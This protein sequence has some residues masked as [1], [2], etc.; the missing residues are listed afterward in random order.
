M[1]Y[2]KDFDE[3][4]YL[5]GKMTKFNALNDPNVYSS[6]R[7]RSYEKPINII[8]QI[9]IYEYKDTG[10]LN[11]TFLATSYYKVNKSLLENSLIHIDLSLISSHQIIGSLKSIQFEIYSIFRRWKIIF[12][13]SLAEI[14]LITSLEEKQNHILTKNF[15]YHFKQS[16]ISIGHRG[17][18]KTFDADALQSTK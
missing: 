9:S 5:N 11:E 13:L 6:F 17:M 2:L 15:D 8:F 14:L 16:C 1:N 3:T 12:H 4:K 18:G 10:A 7:F